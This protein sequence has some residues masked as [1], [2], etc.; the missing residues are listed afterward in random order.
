MKKWI[1]LSFSILLMACTE[2]GKQSR[3]V[4]LQPL[5][6]FSANE[7]KI[8]LEKIRQINPD[9][10]LR[11][12]MPFPTEAYYKPRNRYRAEI[13]LEHLS[14]NTG[15]DTVIAA[16][17]ARDISTTKGDV[18]DW[19][20]MGLGYRP[21]NACLISTF[22]LSPKNRREQFYKVVLHELGHTQ[23]L[24]HCLDKTCLMRDAEGGNP[25]DDEKDFCASCK[26]SLVAQHWK[27]KN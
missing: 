14:K 15:R 5:G 7:A 16:L 19:G 4:V 25:L 3:V 17:S 12:A 9:V 10:I 6:N 2:T 18:Y 22:R 8:V 26:G 1:W 13:I 20:V 27:L 24:P 23:G 11:P 21:G